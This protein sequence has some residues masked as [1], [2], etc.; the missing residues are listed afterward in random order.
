MLLP[1][2]VMWLDLPSTS[3]H[4]H[5]LG[6]GMVCSAHQACHLVGGPVLGRPWREGHC[7]A[8]WATWGLFAAL[9]RVTEYGRPHLSPG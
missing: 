9:G 1:H 4:L 5:P 6:P 2:E 7:G 8:Y 3:D